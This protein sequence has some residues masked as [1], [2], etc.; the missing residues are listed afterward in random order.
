M[1]NKRTGIYG[2]YYGSYYNE[3]EYLTEAE[4]EA[5]ARYIYAY[6]SAKGWTK[7]A[8][9]GLLGNLENESA[10]NPGRWEGNDVGNGPGYGLVQWTPFT[11]YTNWC[12]ENGYDDPSEM[13]TNL[14]RII[15]EM[16][17]GIQYYA[18]DDYPLS[19]SEF[20][21]STASP[22]YLAC[23]FAWN[24]ERSWVVLYGSEEEKEA[25]RQLRGGDANKW[26]SFLSGEEPSDPDPDTPTPDTPEIPD[27]IPHD[28]KG[29]PLWL[30][31]SATR[32]R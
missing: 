16:Q 12:A 23:A 15:Y 19:F 4:K 2:T 17:N 25:L 18:T 3:S 6:L 30:L 24:Y 9:A 32:K 21:K 27:Y 11:K 26:Y 14:I 10:I 20:S 13:D 31:I 7:N 5:N 28:R 8:V 22:Y 1:A 29:L